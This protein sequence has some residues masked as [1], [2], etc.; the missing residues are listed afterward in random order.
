MSGKRHITIWTILLFPLTIIYGLI[1]RI[2]NLM[3]DWEILPSREFDLPVISVGNIRVGGTGKTPHVEYLIEL[4]KE[5]FNIA[6]LSRGYKRKTKRFM[7][8]DE[9]SSVDDI[10]DEPRQLKQKYPE[11]TVAVDRKRVNGIEQLLKL[12]GQTDI[13]LLDD[14]FQHRHVKPGKSILL[15]DYNRMIQDDFLLPS[16]R[17]REP[18]SGKDRANIILVTRTPE[19]IKPME[20]RNIVTNMNL[21]LHQNMYFTHMSFDNF[22]PVYDIENAKESSWFKEKKPPVIMLTGIANPRSLR[23]YARSISTQLVEFTFP[24]HHQYTLKDL[25]KISKAYRS[26]NNPDT[27]ILTTEK[28]AMRLQGLQADADIKQALYYITIHVHFLNDDKKEF[29]HLILDYVRSN[30]RDNILHQTTS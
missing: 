13:I 20:M 12:K 15:M 26:L 24:D 27:L 14:A 22:R 4:M 25:Q 11:L 17:L 28:D 23:K 2:R 16:G 8:A 5:E 6:T 29:N 9:K 19:R 21:A 10:G 3:F 1:V 18:V 30:K 7:I